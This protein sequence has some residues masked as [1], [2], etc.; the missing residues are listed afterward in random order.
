MTPR[1]SPNRAELLQGTLDMLI[2]RTLLFGPA[3]GHEIA[4][5][6]QRTTEEVLQ[7]EHGS[8][9]PALHRMERKGWIAAKWETAKDRNREFKYYRLTPAGR[10]QLGREESKWKKLAEAIALVM[11][12][13]TREGR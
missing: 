3:H 13:A 2:L 5:H 10:K 6:I 8:L 9:Y 4:K 12:P 11:W 7:V 1:E